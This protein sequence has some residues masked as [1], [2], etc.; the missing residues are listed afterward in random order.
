MVSGAGVVLVE[1]LVDVEDALSPESGVVVPPS[2]VPPLP[3]S[4]LVLF[5]A[6]VLAL[7]LAD[8]LSLVDVLVL[9]DVLAFS[10]A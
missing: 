6:E 3:E 8:S 4:P 2:P 1:A 5:A 7:A 10:L 9:A